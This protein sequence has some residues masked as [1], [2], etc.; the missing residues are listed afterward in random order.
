M[1][2]A[3]LPENEYSEL[4]NIRVLRK[5]DGTGFLMIFQNLDAALGSELVRGQYLLVMTSLQL[6]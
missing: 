6:V 5:A 3:F 2:D 4:D 1:H